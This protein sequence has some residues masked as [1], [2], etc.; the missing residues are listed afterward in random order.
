VA[1][2]SMGQ[3]LTF[4]VLLGPGIFDTH[5][6]LGTPQFPLQNAQWSRLHETVLNHPVLK[7][8]VLRRMRSLNDQLL[9]PPGTPAAS[10]NF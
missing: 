4:G 2:F 7:E 6:L 10:G 5:P 3:D 1:D 8:M 9:Q